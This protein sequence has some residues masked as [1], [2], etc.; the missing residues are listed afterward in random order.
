MAIETP[1]YKIV[2]KEGVFELRNY[3]GYIMAEVSIK[4]DS[5]NKASTD[6]FRIIADFI[7]GNNTKSKNISMTAPVVQEFIDSSE[8]IA[9]TAPVNI[10]TES[11]N[12]YNISFIMPSNY[13]L[14]TLPKPNN[15]K[16]HIKKV[17]SFKAAII[18]FSGFVNQT[19]ILKKTLELEDW[20]KKQEL[21]SLGEINTARYNPPWTPWFLRRNEIILRIK[22]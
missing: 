12:T 15:E 7:F 13:T 2:K 14:E 4:S 17:K 3:E 11:I 9:M 18:R 1:K 16:V 6:G 20:V 22:S 19:I 10:S 21:E 5:Y 8:K